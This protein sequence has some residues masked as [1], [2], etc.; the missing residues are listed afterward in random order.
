MRSAPRFLL[1]VAASAAALIAAAPALAQQV[2]PTD[3]FAQAASDIPAD[4]N[5]RFGILPNGMQYAILRNATP[6]G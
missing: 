1:L 6:P 4:S 2:A 3:P 5:V